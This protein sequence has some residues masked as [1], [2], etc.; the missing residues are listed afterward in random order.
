[1]LHSYVFRLAM[2]RIRRTPCTRKPINHGYK[3]VHPGRHSQ[4]LTI[5]SEFPDVSS[6]HYTLLYR[7][8]E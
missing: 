6:P 8:A 2:R 1:M 4:F 3:F 5:F 7:K